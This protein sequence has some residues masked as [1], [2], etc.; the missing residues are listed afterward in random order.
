MVLLRTGSQ[1]RDSLDETFPLHV[2]SAGKFVPQGLP[3]LHHM[4]FWKGDF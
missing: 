2:G 3:T 4:T 1:L